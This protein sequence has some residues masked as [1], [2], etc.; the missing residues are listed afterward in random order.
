M[1]VLLAFAALTV[2]ADHV[3]VH[4]TEHAGFAWLELRDGSEQLY[5]LRYQDGG[6]PDDDAASLLRRAFPSIPEGTPQDVLAHLSTARKTVA[7]GISKD[8]KILFD[9]NL[10]PRAAVLLGLPFSINRADADTL[11]LLPGI[12]PALAARII[13]WREGNGPLTAPEQLCRIHGIGPRTQK[14]LQSY[15]SWQE[16]NAQ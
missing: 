15:F 1:L 6:S 8:G 10:S 7:V 16:G 13:A 3:P 5:R 2:W 4:S 9:K 11:V 14:R 12:G